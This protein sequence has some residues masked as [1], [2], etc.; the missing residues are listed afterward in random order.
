MPAL[1]WKIQVPVADLFTA[2]VDRAK[3]HHERVLYWRDVAEKTRQAV[4]DSVNVSEAIPDA[5]SASNYRSTVDQLSGM[6]VTVDQTLMR[7]FRKASEKYEAHI[8]RLR[9]FEEWKVFFSKAS[10]GSSF[11]VDISDMKTFRLG[12]YS[13]LANEAKAEDDE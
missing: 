1:Q 12:S 13:D 7:E 8:E 6:N 10:A 11:D 3:Y 4:K 2:A 5:F 9:A